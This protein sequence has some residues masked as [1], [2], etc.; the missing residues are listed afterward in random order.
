MT[1]KSGVMCKYLSGWSWTTRV[2]HNH[3]WMLLPSKRNVLKYITWC[4]IE[5]KNCELL[6]EWLFISNTEWCRLKATSGQM[7]NW[8]EVIGISN[9]NITEYH[10]IMSITLY[11]QTWS[12]NNTITLSIHPIKIFKNY[13]FIVHHVKCTVHF[14]LCQL[15]KWLL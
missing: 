9:Q 12:C 2:N 14:T 8:N 7:S 5:T 11:S 15:G 13:V 10:Y 6:K 3:V 4:V 1:Y